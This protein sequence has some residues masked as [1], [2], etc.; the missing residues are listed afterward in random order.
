[1]MTDWRL[2]RDRPQNLK[3]AR[4]LAA[5]DLKPTSEWCKWRLKCFHLFS[6]N[7]GFWNEI[8]SWNGFVALVFDCVAFLVFFSL[9][10]EHLLRPNGVLHHTAESGTTGWIVGMHKISALSRD[11]C[12]NLIRYELPVIKCA[13]ILSKILELCSVNLN[14]LYWAEKRSFGGKHSK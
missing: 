7:E 9:R 14:N 10:G 12:K 11:W 8:R 2:V 3:P 6:A 4:W 1:M 5:W 13:T